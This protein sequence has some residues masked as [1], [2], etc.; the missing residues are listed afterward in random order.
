[1]G[2]T[3][4]W[5]NDFIMSISETSNLTSTSPFNWK[6]LFQLVLSILAAVLLLG[7]AA[8]IAVS[9]VVQY[10]NQGSDGMNLTQ[11]F[12]VAASLAFAGVLVLPSAWYAWKNLAFPAPKPKPRPEPKGFGIIL[13][14]L[15]LVVVPGVLWLGNWVSEYEQLA[16]FVLPL[17]NIIANGLPAFWL[18][19]IGTRGLNPGSPRRQWGIFATGL[20]VSPAV[21][22]VIELFA[23]IGYG[24][25]ALLWAVFN[26]SISS[27]LQVLIFRLQNAAPN[28]DAIFR[29]LLPILLRPG[30]LFA[31]FAFISVIVPIIEEALKPIGVWFLAGQKLTPAQGFAFGVLCG[32]GFGL[33]E[34]LGNTSGVSDAWAILASTRITTLLLHCLTTGLVGWA[35]ASAWSQ[36]RYLR[37]GITY[38][39]AIILHGLWNGMA[40]LSTISSLEGQ[41]DVAIPAKLQQIGNFS[42][43]GIIILLVFNLILYISFNAVLRNSIST[44]DSLSTGV[45]EPFN[46]TKDEATPSVQAGSIIPATTSPNPSNSYTPPL[47]A[48][49]DQRLTSLDN[50]PVNLESNP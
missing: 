20:V 14:L 27:Q 29:I 1:V 46:L 4:F 9:G 18:V 6:S 28:Q 34:N 17:L 10:F 11:T 2:I 5:E 32:A 39:F 45:N 36:K 21:I 38:A 50:P 35:L 37:L 48:N 31:A 24:G 42:S 44:N 30:I 41:V 22:L 19:Y 43:I 7:V 15:V 40:V 3:S 13:T 26:P 49:E 8:L 47:S 33:F 25:L 12:M 23:L 16:W